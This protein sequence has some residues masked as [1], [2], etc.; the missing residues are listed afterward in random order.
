MILDPRIHPFRPDLAARR[1][2]GRVEAARFVEGAPARVIE[3]V[4]PVRRQPRPDAALDTEALFGEAVTVYDED[5]EGWAWVQL[6]RD[7]YVGFMPSHALLKGEAPAPTHRVAALRSFVFPGPSIK[8]PPLAWVSLGSEVRVLREIEERGRVFAVLDNGGTIVARHL[9]PVGTVEPDFVAVAERF[10]GAPYLWGGKSSLGLDC[11]GLV[12]TALRA[13]GIEAPRDSDMQEASLGA[14]AGLD[15]A[16]WRRGDLLFWP[17]HVAIVR[18]GETM[19]HANAFAMANAIEDLAS[20]LAR[21]A[22][23]GTPLRSVKRL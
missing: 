8:E 15:P 23:S 18:D 22:A 1:L 10:L 20:G 14:S 7:G 21:I 9:A 16:G 19:L 17:G 11:S 4:A 3:G 6:A 2:E 12:Q 13:A 5:A